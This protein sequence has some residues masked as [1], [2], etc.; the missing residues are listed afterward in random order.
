M[1]IE[2]NTGNDA[3]VRAVYHAKHKLYVS[4]SW[5][6]DRVKRKQ[7][8]SGSWFVVDPVFSL[9]SVLFWP[10]L[11]QIVEQGIKH[12]TSPGRT[13]EDHV[14]TAALPAKRVACSVVPLLLDYSV[15]YPPR[16]P[17]TET[18]ILCNTFDQ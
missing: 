4:G 7:H 16:T 11:I 9:S 8:E 6:V 14:G 12:I 2:P 1:V 10:Q 5:F 18:L 17:P 13:I 3:R 15:L